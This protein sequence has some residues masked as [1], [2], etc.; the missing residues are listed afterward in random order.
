MSRRRGDGSGPAAATEAS[1]LPGADELLGAAAGVPA[2]GDRL[3]NPLDDDVQLTVYRPGAVPPATWQ[4]LLVYAHKSEPF[5]DPAAGPIDP[6]A[7]MREQVQARLGAD[8]ASYQSLTM[9]NPSTGLAKGSEIE[10]VPVVEGVEFNP[11]RRSFLWYEPVHGEEFRFRADPALDGRMAAG[12]IT[13]VCNALTIATIPL[14]FRVQRGGLATP[15]EAVAARP[16]HKIFASYSHLDADVVDAVERSVE[17]LG[18]RFL[19]DVR[20]LRSGEIWNDRL[21]ELIREAD[22]FQLFWS[23]N[24]MLSPYVRQEYRYAL[25]LNRPNFVRPTYWE[26][27]MPRRDPDLPPPE[28]AR[29]HFF[30]LREAGEPDRPSQHGGSLPALADLS[31]VACAPAAPAAASPVASTPAAPSPV[32]G[33]PGAP[34]APP[35][36]PMSAAPPPWPGPP[37]ALTAP[38]GAGGAPA[39]ARKRSRL[40][41]L[42]GAALALVIL[43]AGGAVIEAAISN[44][45]FVSGAASKPNPT[46]SPS[47]HVFEPL[48]LTVGAAPSAGAITDL[49]P[50][51]LAASCQ[52]LDDQ[53]KRPDFQSDPGEVCTDPQAGGVDAFFYAVSQAGAYAE[54]TSIASGRDLPEV[55][56]CDPSANS[57]LT[58][59]VVLAGDNLLLCFV[60]NTVVHLEWTDSASGLYT[61]IQ[62]RGDTEANRQAAYQFWQAI[63]G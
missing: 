62:A 57:D 26:Q 32:A 40:T 54:A 31:S 27:P 25:S 24:S 50:P 60:D 30:A 28:L 61:S 2:A 58:G 35:A 48:G 52:A 42:A 29:I 9:D 63:S 15:L 3:Q 33:A 39:P 8:F 18:N 21:M 11:R 6:V 13:V 7:M 4:N 14:K 37:P 1:G 12:S 38:P 44:P 23:T 49:L 47:R 56:S 51:W 36:A 10:F 53:N 45:P 43:V 59:E 46:G 5:V 17:S 55:S 34:A 16:Y 41:L 22:I 19:R 20:D